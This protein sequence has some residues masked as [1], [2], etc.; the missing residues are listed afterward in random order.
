M[1]DDVA[2]DFVVNGIKPFIIRAKE[3]GASRHVWHLPTEERYLFLVRKGR[4]LIKC[5][6]G[7]LHICALL[8]FL[9]VFDMRVGFHPKMQRRSFNIP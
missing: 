1:L 2:E 7:A 9:F 6:N 8:I 4:V 3:R 5:F